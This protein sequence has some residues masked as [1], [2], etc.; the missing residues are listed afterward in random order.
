M[1]KRSDAARPGLAPGSRRTAGTMFAALYGDLVPHPWHEPDSEHDAYQLFHQRSIAMGWLD[2]RSAGGGAEDGLRRAP[3]LWGMNDAGWGHPRAAA[4]AGPVSWFQVEASEVP[5]DR[6]LPVRPFLRCALDVTARAGSLDL[7][8]VQLLLPVQGLDPAARPPYA[9]VPA[10]RTTDWFA[11]RAPGAGTAVEVHVDSGRDPSVPAVARRLTDRLAGLD[12]DVFVCASAGVAGGAAT[13]APPLHDGLRNG[14]PTHGMVLRGELAE[15]SGD[16]VGWLAEVVAGCAALLGV[17]SPLLLS[18]AR[19]PPPADRPAVSAGRRRGAGTAAP[20]PDP[21]VC[22]AVSGRRRDEHRGMTQTLTAPAAAPVRPD[23]PLP[24]WHRPLLLVAAAMVLLGLVAVGGLLL[25]DRVL[26]GAPIWLKPLK[27]TISIAIYAA[28]LSWLLSL[29]R[30]ARRTG[31]WMGTVVAV[32]LAVEMVLMVVQIGI[33]GRQLHFNQATSLDANFTVVMALTIYVLWAATLVIALLAMVQRLGDRATTLAIRLGLVVTLVGLALGMLMVMPTPE[34]QAAMDAGQRLAIVGAHSVGVPDGGPGL[35]F[36]TWSTTGGDLRIPHFVGIHAL[37]LLPLSAILVAR[38]FP[39]LGE[40]VR[41]RLVW[42]AAG[43]Y[44]GLL[45]LVTWQ[46]LRGQPL[47]HPDG[48]TLGA[49]GL[50]V[51]GAAGGAGLALRGSRAA[52]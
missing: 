44:A 41:V 21:P 4:G 27:F 33:R 11:D 1:P 43:A 19:T 46:A 13:V 10:T 36:L 8:A 12:Q 18:V 25:D 5:G 38:L 15:W 34:Q 49:L 40:P 26:V 22:R 9:P 28:T 30:R 17:R 2:D 16:A 52:R 20:T 42:V 45:A 48:A 29:S 51:L 32:A 50:L 47:V 7:A 23:G 6:P 35:P 14:P 31:W 39:R 37:Q 24:R 3:G